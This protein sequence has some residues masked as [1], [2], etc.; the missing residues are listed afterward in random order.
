MR[1][2][3]M[4]L[5]GWRFNCSECISFWVV[6]RR[7]FLVRVLIVPAPCTSPLFPS[8]ERTPFMLHTHLVEALRAI[9]HPIILVLLPLA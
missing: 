8:L 6:A 9:H 7:F 3:E 2:D 5:M 1:G 4:P